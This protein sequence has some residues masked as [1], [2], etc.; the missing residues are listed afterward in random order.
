MY[1]GHFE[2]G[3]WLSCLHHRSG[4]TGPFQDPDICSTGWILAVC[5]YDNSGSNEVK[6]LKKKLPISYGDKLKNA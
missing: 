3:G 5:T 1:K 2:P 4:Y 6:D